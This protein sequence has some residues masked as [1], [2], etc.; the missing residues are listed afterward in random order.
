LKGAISSP[1]KR[2]A[3]KTA[4]I[5]AV[6]AAGA[7]G[8]VVLV[9]HPFSSSCT[10][11]TCIL[12]V[13]PGYTPQPTTIAVLGDS[14]SAG[15]GT[16]LG[17]G[18]AFI[19]PTDDGA[20]L[21]GGDTTN[22]DNCHRSSQAYAVT[23]FNAG[24]FAACSGATTGE[25]DSLQS[26]H[27]SFR[28]DG[29]K[30][31]VDHLTDN[32]KTVIVSA[33][34]DD[35]GF[36][37]VLTACTSTKVV[38]PFF[39]SS[40][41]PGVCQSA[42]DRSE[43]GKEYSPGFPA[44]QGNLISLYHQILIAAP[45]AHIYAVGYPHIFPPQGHSG[46][47][48]V[49]TNDQV[50]L[51]KATDDLNSIIQAAAGEAGSRVTY[52]DTTNVLYN[53]WICGYSGNSGWI[54]DL[55]L[56]AVPHDLFLPVPPFHLTVGP[57]NCAVKNVASWIV[58]VKS[59]TIG[60]VQIPVPEVKIGV[61]SQSYHPTA[62][63]SRAIGKK[64]LECIDNAS[65][66][67]PN[68]PADAV[69]AW[70]ATDGGCASTMGASLQH[71]ASLLP[72]GLGP[73]GDDVQIADLDQLAT[74]PLS[75]LDEGTMAQQAEGQADITAL[76][77]FFGTDR[78]ST[79]FTGSCPAPSQ[80]AAPAPPSPGPAPSPAALPEVLDNFPNSPAAVAV[81]PTAI[82]F[83]E[84]GNDALTQ[85]SWGSWTAASATGTGNINLNN[86]G[87]NGGL[88]TVTSIPVFVVLSEPIAGSQPLFTKITVIDVNEGDNSDV[89]VAFGNVW[90]RISNAITA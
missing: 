72:A 5:V 61:C 57:D 1:I 45:N 55:Q 23:V 59:V 15:E 46:C 88:G 28:S 65:T 27:M 35:A 75:E 56:E 19:P 62:D 83:Y 30:T 17:D 79:S 49:G 82:S 2:L 67:E 41:D 70:N 22:Q 73:E 66:C 47:N 53:H 42:I 10:T 87:P 71:V 89:W 40:A 48:G 3:A 51:N 60:P 37:G 8:G 39:G 74:L 20:F 68:P 33:G 13:P 84:D 29:N 25:I 58:D 7:A 81:Q 43:T 16:S 63:G 54:N 18:S 77:T 69:A 24:I 86:T 26:N 85:L 4:F 38:I 12:Q 9:T 11:P 14:Y 36:S 64:I 76:N 50:A 31:Q 80:S 90:T 32:V 44:I 52:V 6:I 34:G 21:D 78:T